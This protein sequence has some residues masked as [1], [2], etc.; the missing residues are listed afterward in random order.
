MTGA[1]PE[2]PDLRPASCPPV[3]SY[4]GLL[5]CLAGLREP[6]RSRAVPA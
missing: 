5:G 6:D 4:D 1:G 3:A 2:V